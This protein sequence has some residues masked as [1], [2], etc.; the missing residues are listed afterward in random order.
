MSDKDKALA[1]A[2]GAE[3]AEAE[4]EEGSQSR[5]SWVVG[6][7]LVPASV[8]G[9]I[10][11]SGVLVGVHLHDSWFTRMIVWIVELFV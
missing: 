6:W 10:W 11:G 4:G 9:V 3:V 2:E 5:L 8:I 7:V 1:R